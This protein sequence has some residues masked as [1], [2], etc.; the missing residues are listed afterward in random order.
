MLLKLKK[1]ISLIGNHGSPCTFFVIAKH[2][3][4]TGTGNL[5]F[6]FTCAKSQ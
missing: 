1:K 3:K 2:M 6:F 4:H 5:K